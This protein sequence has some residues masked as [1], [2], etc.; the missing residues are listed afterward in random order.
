VAFLEQSLND[1]RLRED[2]DP[3]PQRVELLVCVH[4]V[5]LNY[6]DIAF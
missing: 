2:D 6:R 4:A 1:L 5:S 3:R